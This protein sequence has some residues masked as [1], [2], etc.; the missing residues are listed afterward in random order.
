MATSK[1]ISLQVSDIV[2]WFREKELVINETF[3]RHSVWTPA[4][5]TYLVD[6]VLNELPIPKIYIRSKVDTKSQATLREV[7]DGQQRVRALV[8][9]ANNQLRLG[10][11]S[12]QFS[13]KKYEDLDEETQSKF[14]GYTLSIEQLLNA[15][16]DDVID[17]FARLNS[18]IVSLNAAEKRHAQF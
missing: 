10:N 12:D 1:S 16:D 14:L 6:T 4:A 18:Y 5:K 7:V 13:G 2:R 17:I 9:F 15:T 3:Q 11:R 8:E